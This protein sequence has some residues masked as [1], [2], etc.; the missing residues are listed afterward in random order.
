MRACVR[1]RVKIVYV[2]VCVCRMRLWVVMEAAQRIVEACMCVCVCMY[3][4]RGGDGGYAENCRTR[5]WLCVF[6]G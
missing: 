4:I 1:V 6:V 2:C 3:E 5:V